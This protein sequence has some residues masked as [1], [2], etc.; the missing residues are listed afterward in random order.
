M[1]KADIVNRVAEMSDV[2][3]VK[4]AQAVDTIIE[5]MKDGAL[6]RQADRAARLRRLPGARPQEGRRPQPQDR[7]RGRHH[8]GQDRALQTRQGP[9]EPLSVPPS[10]TPERQLTARRRRRLPRCCR[11]TA[12][13]PAPCRP[14]ALR[15]GAAALRRSPSSPPP[16]WAPSSR[17]SL[18]PHRRAIARLGAL[19]LSPTLRSRSSGAIPALLRLGPALRLADALRSCSATRWATTLAC[20]RYGLPVTPPYFLPAP[21]GLGTFGAFIRI[22]APIRDQARA[23]RRRGRRARS[24]A[25]SRSCPSWCSAR[26]VDA[27]RALAAIVGRGEARSLLLLAPQLLSSWFAGLFHGPLPPGLV[28]DSIPSPGG[29]GRHVRHHAQP[30]AAGAARR[31]PHPLR[32]GRPAAGAARPAALAGARRARILVAGLVA[33]VRRRAGAAAP[34]SAGGATSASRSTPMGA[35][36]SCAVALLIFVLCFMPVPMQEVVLR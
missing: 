31:R 27:R 26:L 23:A 9:Q 36:S 32:R 15:P 3:R 28:L 34:P 11:P 10:Q 17:W 25:S 24:P 20:R 35:G 18:D 22:R 6:R 5:A 4:A 7:R 19:P 16:R 29:L 33:L 14:A 12:T 30:A 2:P 13:R 21:L 8:P 1:I